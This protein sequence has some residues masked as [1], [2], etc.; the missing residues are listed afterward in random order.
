[1]LL[2]FAGFFTPQEKAY[3]R[4]IP[5][6]LKAIP[7]ILNTSVESNNSAM[8]K[9]FWNYL[10]TKIKQKLSRIHKPFTSSGQY[11]IDRYD[12]GGNSGA[13]SYNELAI[14][15]AEVLNN[16]VKTEKIT[17]IIEFGCGDG[18]QLSLSQYP[19]YVG[20]DISPKALDLCKSR[21]IGDES[22]TFK[23]M[24]DYAGEK[25]ELTLSLDVIFHLVEDAVF[26]EYMER[27]F[28]SS[29]KFVVIYSSNTD[30]QRKKQ[31]AHNR[32]R[33]FS[34]WILENEMQWELHNFIP[35]KY[36]LSADGTKGTFS[37]FYFYKKIHEK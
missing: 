30:I 19:S 28:S 29:E 23:F 12:S 9:S 1:V 31:L 26:F 10:W 18:N 20:F 14:F 4:K 36:P 3:L 7:N 15:K 33:N 6:F 24:N 8:P 37:D 17:K 16:F 34:K 25:A 35:N 5:G 11:W 32:H 13:G 2:F 27:L 21:F 22:K